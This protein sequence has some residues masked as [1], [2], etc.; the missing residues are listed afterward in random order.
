MAQ[1]R[2]I[3]LNMAQRNPKNG[4]KTPDKA[5]YGPKTPKRWRKDAKK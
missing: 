4:T 2:Q 3:R 5:K 1:R